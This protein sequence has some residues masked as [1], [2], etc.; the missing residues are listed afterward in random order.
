MLF[1][2]EMF[3]V[4]LC[5]VPEAKKVKA[6]AKNTRQQ[7]KR[8]DGASAAGKLAEPLPEPTSNYVHLSDGAHFENLALYELVRR[9]C[10]YIIV[11]DC[12][13]D[14]RVVFDDFGNAMRRIR[15]DF[16]VEIEIDLAPLRPDA[17]TG[18]SRQHMVAGTI[19]YDREGADTGV[20]LLFKPT[21][22][23]DETGDVAQY[24]AR[25][26][27]FPHE[28]TGDQF[29]DEAQW[30]SY[31]RLGEHATY[32]ALRFVERQPIATESAE[33]FFHGARQEWYPGPAGLADRVVAAMD[34][35]GALEA[36]LRDAN[37]MQLRRELFPELREIERVLPPAERGGNGPPD[38][39]SPSEMKRE[40]ELL[41][42]PTATE[43]ERNL[44]FVLEVFR[45]MESVWLT[46]QLD[47]H[48]NHPLNLGIFNLLQRWAYAPSCR[49]WWPLIRP[50]H[51]PRFRRFIEEHL[52]LADKDY[53]MVNGS[54]AAHDA[55]PA[56]LAW[57]H[58]LRSRPPKKMPPAG[59]KYYDW[60]I[61]LPV[62]IDSRDRVD[63]K[64]VPM[65]LAVAAV[66]ESP[67]RVKWTSE[68]FF[69]PPSL[70]GSGTGGV[71]LRALLERLAKPGREFVVELIQ[72][73]HGDRSDFAVRQERNDLI[74]FYK[75]AG[76]TVVDRPQGI[77]PTEGA[78]AYMR[79]RRLE[80]AAEQR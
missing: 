57:M 44:P 11:S 59:A 18:V 6:D 47:A 54:I 49:L 40:A 72:V 10:R 2:S 24:R 48:W 50:M 68:D 69:V 17:E 52:A 7:E 42:A 30:E 66:L 25:N 31:R 3:G 1:L 23:G 58:W 33:S 28:S 76:F 75:S 4:T 16:G 61:P 36:Q 74:A 79:Q 53:P 55:P 21:M 26:P 15:E 73:R 35:V 78:F 64:P 8:G 62:Q 46:C 29:Y 13:S 5:G 45:W 65:Q 37:A 67:E 63:V 38:G 51:G 60:V 32:S 22:T 71:F 56:G 39:T 43:I 34:R 9:H 27:N 20:I 19:Y 70:W 12:G 80:G 77:E 14:S 41:D